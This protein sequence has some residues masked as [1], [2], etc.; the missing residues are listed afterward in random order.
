MKKQEYQIST[1]KL[2]LHTVINHEYLHI[3]PQ[4]NDIVLKINVLKTHLLQLSKLYLL[5]L[6]HNNQPLP[7]INREYF[8]CLIRVLTVSNII[9]KDFTKSKVLFD[10]IQDFYNIHYKDIQLD[11]ID[12]TGYREIVRYLINDIVQD[13]E[14]NIILHHYDYVKSFY[15]CLFG[16]KELQDEKD[17]EQVKLLKRHKLKKINDA[18]NN[19]YD[20]TCT[21]EDNHLHKKHILPQRE[22]K[23]SVNYDLKCDPQSYLKGMIYMNLFCENREYTIKSACPLKTS[24]VPGHICLDTRT[25]VDLFIKDSIKK[26]RFLATGGL[27]MFKDYIWCLVFKTNKKAFNTKVHKFKG[28]IYTDGVSVSIL[29]DNLNKKFSKKKVEEKYITDVSNVERKQLIKKEVVS[30]DP[31]KDDLIYCIKGDFDNNLRKFRYTNNQRSKE[32]RKRKNRKILEKEKKDREDILTKEDE[33]SKLSRK[34]NKYEKFEEYSKK[35]NEVNVILRTFYYNKLWRRLRLSTYVRTKRS[36]ERMLKS[37]KEQMGSP[38]E[39]FIAIGDWSQAQQMKFKEPTKG[40][41]F[42]KLFRKAGYKVYLVN[43]FRTSKMCCKCKKEKGECEKFLK[44]KSP[45]PWRNGEMIMC[46]GLV[47]CKT[48]NTMFNRDMNS[49]EN[50]KEVVRHALNKMDRPKYLTRVSSNNS[51]TLEGVSNH[52]TG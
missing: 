5:Y 26:K 24:V 52:E 16:W 32:T 36:E 12:I 22:L 30:I 9:R 17:K 50:I 40:K 15:R 37:F 42:R 21:D 2:A 11:I 43:E 14:Y 33:L 35:K 48:C 41:G 44:V 49:S 28:M 38:E 47:K 34:T 20:T 39:T 29:R 51:D 4:I 27:E 8:A 6:F 1:T 19:F 46:H 18:I 31:N 7:D 10:D 45:R 13:Y 25:I 3:L 23:K